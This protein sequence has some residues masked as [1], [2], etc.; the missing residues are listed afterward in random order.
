MITKKHSVIITFA[1]C[2]LLVP[3][4]GNAQGAGTF[5]SFIPFDASQGEFT[6]GVAVDKIGNVYVAMPTRAAIVRVNAADLSQDTVAVLSA[7]FPVLDAPFSLAFGTGN[8]DR[9]SLFVSNGG[10]SALFVPGLPWAGPGLVKIEV[11]IPG[12]PLP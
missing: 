3:A 6:E 4:A 8:G 11:G 9:E 2:T 1:A 12:L 7:D 5:P 10:V